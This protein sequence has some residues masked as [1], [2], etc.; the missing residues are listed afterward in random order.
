MRETDFKQ[1]TQRDWLAFT[2]RHGKTAAI[3]MNDCIL[4]RAG[5]AEHLHDA[6]FLKGIPGAGFS[7]FGEI[8]G[9]PINQTLSA[10]VFFHHDVKA[11]TQFPVEYASYA[12]HYAQRALRCWEA[13]NRVQSRVVNYQQELEAATQS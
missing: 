9:V 10:L 8:L 2:R 1:A 4:R 12:A 13:L 6:H 11:M 5:N 3:L 7:G